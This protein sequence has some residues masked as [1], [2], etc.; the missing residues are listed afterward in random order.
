M[1]NYLYYGTIF[2]PRNDKLLYNIA[3]SKSDFQHIYPEYI[4]LL[5]QPILS[6]EII[7]LGVKCLTKAFEESLE[8][9]GLKNG[10]HIIPLS[11]GLD[12]RSILG[13]LLNNFETKEII[14]F[15]YGYKGTLD[16]EI[17]RMIANKVDVKNISIDTSSFE[18]KTQKM[19]DACK[20]TGWDC[21]SN[22]AYAHSILKYGPEN[23][24]WSGFMGGTR[25]RGLPKSP[26]KN[27]EDAVNLFIEKNKLKPVTLIPQYACNYLP[28]KYLPKQPLVN[29]I[30]VPY[31]EQL[32]I[33]IYQAIEIWRGMFL[34][35]YDWRA[36]YI[37][38]NWTGLAFNLPEEW[39]KK[40]IYYRKVLI[41]AFPKLFDN[42]PSK[43]YPNISVS[44]NSLMKKIIAK[45][46][47]VIKRKI[48]KHFIHL[49]PYKPAATLNQI[50][51]DWAIRERSDVQLTILENIEDL[52]ARKIIDWINTKQL[53]DDH[54]NRYAN[55]GNLLNT[56]AMLELRIKA[57]I[58]TE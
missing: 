36:P 1:Y 45:G 31:D 7:D 15:T 39:H 14:T 43:T 32:N 42:M 27:W 33:I 44:S 28:G 19:V 38:P 53:W 49:L 40:Q 6:N 22:V 52:R 21:F 5:K 3:S 2:L 11:G 50:D 20:V 41:R 30:L 29:D 23:V 4:R 25:R 12:S 34:D 51:I 46:N 37:N 8:S 9:K 26:S 48:N 10:K 24:Y 47:Y 17:G 54:I 13:F 35:G 55:N 57:G 58:I 18:W 56:L 16:Y